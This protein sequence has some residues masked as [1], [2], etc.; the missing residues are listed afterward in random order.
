MKTEVLDLRNDLRNGGEPFG[1]IMSAAAKVGAGESLLLLT[2]F[3][4]VP[5]YN[6]MAR[7]G[8]THSV[9]RLE[10]GDWEIRFT[11]KGDANATRP[12]TPAV[13]PSCGSPTPA[14]V[15]IVDVDARGL[16]PPQPMVMIL[17][18]V[19]TLS[20]D[21]ELRA[22]TNR[23]PMHLF[24]ELESRGFSSQTEEENDGSFVTIIRRA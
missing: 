14:P 10:S 24:P 15:E 5:L 2:P 13:E 9:S 3:E 8:F 7:Q 22:R 20:P 17:E 18:A 4:P 23:R 1:K 19:A 11:R 16:P 12:G 6:V 21:A